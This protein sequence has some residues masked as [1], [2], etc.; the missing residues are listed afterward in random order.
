MGELGPG[1]LE[2]LLLRLRRRRRRRRRDEGGDR[3]A[4][5]DPAW[6]P[7]GRNLRVT[8]VFPTS[9]VRVLGRGRGTLTLD[10][11]VV[12]GRQTSG[13]YVSMGKSP[14]KREP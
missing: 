12:W 7:G 11:G 4:L 2:M 14:A 6:K 5:K 10:R 13:V 3:A 9:A 1:D 8:L